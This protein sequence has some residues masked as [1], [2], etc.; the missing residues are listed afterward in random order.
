MSASAGN[1]RVEVAELTGV[2]ELHEAA[3]LLTGVWGHTLVAP[4]MLRAWSFTGNYV[5]GARAGGPLIGVAAGFLTGGGAL[6][7][8]ITGVAAGA[9]GLGVGRALKGHQREW[10]LERG[11]RRVEW[12]FDPLVRR[13]AHFNLQVLGALP[14]GYLADFYGTMD[15]GLNSG[16]P[17][18]RLHI[19]W[20][21]DKGPPGEPPEAA[22][23][24]RAGARIGL[25]LD[26]RPA[27]TPAGPG[28]TL[29]AIPADIEALRAA[30]PAL[31]AHWRT[32]V[33]A[34]L[35]P[36]LEAGHRITGIT[37]EG[38]YVVEEPCR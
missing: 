2:D 12:T 8:H 18:D 28:V 9:R 13:N 4:G 17:S 11:I 3:S 35:E 5:A 26:G 31:A 38:Y 7:S 32:A 23:L 27:G 37:R 21:L 14:D 19:A 34:A 25:G 36:A 6:H 33:R 30:R 1:A 20:E 24:V 15:D 22:A 29:V 16:S 10:A